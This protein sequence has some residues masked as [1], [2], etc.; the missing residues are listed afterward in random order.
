MVLLLFTNLQVLPKM[1]RVLLNFGK[2]SLV[3]IIIFF[4]MKGSKCVC[5]LCWENLN[6]HQFV[7]LSMYFG[8]FSFE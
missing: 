2:I 1:K 3:S 6:L 5:F 4:K 8:C 7:Y